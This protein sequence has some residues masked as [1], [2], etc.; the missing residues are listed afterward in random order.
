MRA[1]HDDG[2]EN[3]AEAI[4]GFANMIDDETMST[5]TDDTMGPDDT[6]IVEEDSLANCWKKPPRS[7]YSCFS[8]TVSNASSTQEST[9]SS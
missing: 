6:D 5:S 4:L 7:V 3:T 8:A 2:A 9:V 1:Y